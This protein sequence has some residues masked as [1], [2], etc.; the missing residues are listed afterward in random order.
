MLLPTVE[1]ARR[2]VR[3]CSL[4]L[5][6]G[7]ATLA[8]SPAHAGRN[9]DGKLPTSQSV[10]KGMG[11]SEKVLV[12]LDKSGAK[13]VIL[14]RAG[15]DLSKYN[16]RYSHLGYAY[17]SLEGPWRVLHKLNECGTAVSGI[18]KQGLGEFF[19]DD[20]FQY[21]AAWVVPTPAIQDALLATLLDKTKYGPLH[22]NQY[23]MVSYAWGQKYQQSN[24]WA[25][26][27]L[28]AAL[29]PAVRNRDQAQA[30]LKFKGYTP[31]TLNIGTLARL[32]GRVTQANIAFDDHPN[33]KRF[34]GQ[35]ETV[36][37]DSIFSWLQR[38]GMSGPVVTL[39]L[40]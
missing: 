35:I 23:S 26:E 14:A 17:K 7:V 32:G 8:G 33:D 37:V 29:E 31:S 12:A 2:F 16:L 40:E 18:F 1:S 15:S 3:A 9:C 20:L 30:W 21:E 36:T 27:V 38:S 11:L 10:I 4:M 25:N 39:A 5:A 34:A 24:Q 19:L 13:V 28:A 6:A 22:N